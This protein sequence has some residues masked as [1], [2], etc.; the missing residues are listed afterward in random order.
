MVSPWGALEALFSPSTSELK[1][2]VSSLI[3]AYFEVPGVERVKC[4]REVAKLYDKRS[5]AAHESQS[6]N[7]KI[8]QTLS[9]CFVECYFKLL[10]AKKRHPRMNLRACFLVRCHMKKANQNKTK[11]I[12]KHHYLKA[13]ADFVL[14]QN[15]ASVEQE[16]V[17][18][19]QVLDR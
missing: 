5:T 13:L 7:R 2:R 8:C 4:Q 17:H 6:T 3:A 18:V 12:L 9:T 19:S 14:W 11:K 15:P 1:F 10:I 16:A